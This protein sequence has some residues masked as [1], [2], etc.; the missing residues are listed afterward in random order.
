MQYTGTK[1]EDYITRSD[2]H[3]WL[4]VSFTGSGTLTVTGDVIGD[5]CLIGG[6]SNGVGS[7]GGGGAYVNNHMAQI[8]KS[9]VVTIGASNGGK[10]QYQALTANGVTTNR[11][12]QTG[13]GGQAL[14]LAGTGTGASTIPCHDSINFR[15]IA[16]A[17]GAGARLDTSSGTEQWYGGGKGG[18]NGSN[19]LKGTSGSASPGPGGYDG[20]GNGGSYTGGNGGNATTPGSGGGGLGA[21]D[22]WLGNTGRGYQGAMYILIDTTLYQAV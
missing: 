11:N 21:W 8:L 14:G 12:G 15:S 13:G 6:G 7:S 5:L 3:V 17:G 22:S 2:G 1:V 20:G 4:R 10:T 19:G 18:S 9:G 16:A